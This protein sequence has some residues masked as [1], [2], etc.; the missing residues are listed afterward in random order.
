MTDSH[1]RTHPDAQLPETLSDKQRARIIEDMACLKA[2]YAYHGKEQFG[3]REIT[4]F[5][6]RYATQSVTDLHNSWTEFVGRWLASRQ[7]MPPESSE[8]RI[9][10]FEPWL[11][12]QWNALVTDISRDY[13]FVLHVDV[14]PSTVANARDES[15]ENV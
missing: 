7:N 5:I 1:D 2:E 13:G 15:K 12:T 11:V 6:K 4:E 8:F 3:A 10:E 9:D 14:S